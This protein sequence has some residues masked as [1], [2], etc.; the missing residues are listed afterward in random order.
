ME[1]V[2]VGVDIEGSAGCRGAEAFVVTR[3]GKGLNELVE[4]LQVVG[5]ALIAVE[6]TGGFETIVAAAIAGAN[7]PLAVVNPAQ[8]RHFAR[9][10]GQHAKRSLTARSSGRAPRIS[11]TIRHERELAAQ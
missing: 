9:A 6:A 7:L 10:V 4:R 11:G 1:A 2:Y 3:D 5:P 8:I